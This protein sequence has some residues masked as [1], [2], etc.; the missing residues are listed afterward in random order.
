M[1]LEET[2][3]EL[4]TEQAYFEKIR[5]RLLK[6]HRGKFALIKNEEL[7]GVFDTAE[8][9]YVAGVQKFGNVAFLIKQVV[10]SEREAHIP[11]MTLGLLR[12]V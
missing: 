11:A 4:Q 7:V 12:A 6:D 9:A 5:E 1:A 8:N 10:E 2:V 3:M